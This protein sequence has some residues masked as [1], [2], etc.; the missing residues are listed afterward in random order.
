MSKHEKM[1]VTRRDGYVSAE[2]DLTGEGG[3]F[4][5][6]LEIENTRLRIMLNK[7]M[8]QQHQFEKAADDYSKISYIQQASYFFKKAVFSKLVSKFSFLYIEETAL[9]QCRLKFGHKETSPSF[10]TNEPNFWN[11]ETVQEMEQKKAEKMQQ[12]RLQKENYKKMRSEVEY[13]KMY[14]IKKT[15]EVKAI[16]ETDLAWE[17][18]LIRLI[19]LPENKSVPAPTVFELNMQLQPIIPHKNKYYTLLVRR[20]QT[21]IQAGEI[22]FIKKLT[23]NETL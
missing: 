14:L 2:W 19:D 5:P 9:L 15:P 17:G 11:K 4:M 18:S 7:L 6:D 21:V 20:I 23:G 22:Q 8:L 12:M 1:K 16:L 3:K 13:M 10:G